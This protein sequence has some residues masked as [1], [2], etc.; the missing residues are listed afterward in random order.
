M[1]LN[2]VQVISPQQQAMQRRVNKGGGDIG[3]KI[4]MVAGGVIGGMA[5][6]PLGAAAGAQTGAGFGS[7]VGEQV[8][9]TTT[10]DVGAMDR[11]MASAGVSGPQ[12]VGSNH[13]EEL[14]QSL[15]ALKEAP[16]PMQ[17][18]YTK[19]LM[20]AYVYSASKNGVA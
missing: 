16:E 5:G 6:G 4:G 2:Q 7:M 18:E 10:E 1:P 8:K 3:S 13:T 20:T 9:P 17:R 15:M 12:Q 11:R 19:P 14:K